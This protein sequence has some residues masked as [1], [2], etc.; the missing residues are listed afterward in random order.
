MPWGSGIT[1][2]SSAC[3]S[4]GGYEIADLVNIFASHPCFHAAGDINAE[5]V[6]LLNRLG[7]DG[8]ELCNVVRYGPIGRELEAFGGLT[9]KRPKR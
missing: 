8:W 5:R 6:R 3:R 2:L 4:R 1:L 7:D 9:F